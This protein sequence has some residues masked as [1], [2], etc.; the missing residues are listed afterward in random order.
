ML[1]VGAAGCLAG[2]HAVTARSALAQRQCGQQHSRQ[3]GRQ[4][5][6]HNLHRHRQR[7]QAHS[8]SCDAPALGMQRQ[9]QQQPQTE[10]GGDGGGGGG[11]G[12]GGG[13]GGQPPQRGDSSGGGDPDDDAGAGEPASNPFQR[14]VQHPAMTASSA[15]PPPIV[16]APQRGGPIVVPPTT[17]HHLELSLQGRHE[18][19]VAADGVPLVPLEAGSCRCL[20][21][22][23]GAGSEPRGTGRQ[24]D[25]A[26]RGRPQPGACSRIAVCYMC[27]CGGCNCNACHT[28]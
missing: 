13:S 6:Q 7:L 19:S 20:R 16:Q 25:A 21:C 27:W 24:T 17:G 10:T 15:A 12:W 18:H 2:Q 22:A 3:R 1:R 26:F 28:L 8:T 23:G 11:W 5:W 9:R 14:Y 4:Q